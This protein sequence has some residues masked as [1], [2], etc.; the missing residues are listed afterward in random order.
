MCRLGAAVLLLSTTSRLLV[1]GNFGRSILIEVLVVIESF[2]FKFKRIVILDLVDMY[3]NIFCC[4]GS[5]N[6]M[7]VIFFIYINDEVVC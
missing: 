3:L 6:G 2:N 5:F 4:C 1:G 7:T